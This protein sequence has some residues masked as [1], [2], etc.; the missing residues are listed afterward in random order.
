MRTLII[1]C[2]NHEE[3]FGKQLFRL[4]GIAEDV[5]R[6]TGVEIILAPA[7]PFLSELASKSSLPV[8]SQGVTNAP[9]GPTTGAVIL[10]A[11][12]AAGA[13]G[14]ILDHSEAFL[15]ATALEELVRRSKEL[16]LKTCV[17]AGSPNASKL[18]A[19]LKPDYIA[20]ELQELIGTGKAIS[21]VRPDFVAAVLQVVR[22]EGFEGKILCGAGIRSGNDAARAV[23]LGMDGIV[24]S[25][26]VVK[27][28][29]R[30]AT[31]LSLARALG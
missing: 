25:S 11:A 4:N 16:A 5:A 15:T 27:A 13:K 28:P 24:V 17:C 21:K 14:A 3:A 20:A 23:E 2:K 19:R 18:A 31:L 30:Q 12:K 26:S 6:R 29:D 8:F 9:A 22:N 10:E 1:N 7:T